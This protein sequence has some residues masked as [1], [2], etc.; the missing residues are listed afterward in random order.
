MR[1]FFFAASLLSILFVPH[2]SY[3]N[4]QA[5]VV[6]HQAHHTH[7]VRTYNKSHDAS[8]VDINH[9]DAKQ[10]TSLKGIGAK[11]AEAIV[12]YRAAHGQFKSAEDLASVHGIGVK[13]LKRLESDNP[14]RITINTAP[15]I[16]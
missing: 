3:A 14:G 7:H 13:G 11:K 4:D 10:L 1:S 2:F 6:H 15:N 16:K 5:V 8:A 12:N 9:A